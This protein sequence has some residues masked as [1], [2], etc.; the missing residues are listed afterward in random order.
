[1]LKQQLKRFGNVIFFL[2]IMGLTIYA[3][4]H[5]QNLDEI[6]TSLREITLPY[7]FCAV[8]VALF[9]VGAEGVI[10][11]SLLRSMHGN[12]G[13]IK[14]IGYAFVGF[15]Y[16]GITPSAS[17][18]QP[19]QLLY[20]KR[21]GNRLSE[22]SVV[23]MTVALLYKFVLVCMGIGILLFWRQPLRGYLRG[24]YGLFLIG[25]VLNTS[26]VLVLLGAMLAPVLIRHILFAIDYLLVKL[27]ILKPSS[28]RRLRIDHFIGGYQ[29]AVLFLKSHLLKVFGAI[30]F[31]FFQRI[32][33]FGLPFIVYQGFSLEG[34]SFLT[35]LCLQTSIYI[36][37]DMLP[38]PGAQGITE[39]MYRTVFQTVFTGAYLM[40]GLYVTRGISFYLMLGV[41]LLVMLAFQIHEK[42]ALIHVFE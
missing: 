41:S 21:D 7:L 12:S 16:S 35:I 10:I 13:L 38:I 42:R 33:V 2:I 22:S 31:T 28:D 8:M 29:E 30:L 20:M 1:M 18:G 4:L 36:A 15:F 32:C 17:G 25:M 6:A 37:V 26:L 3:V 27:H 9:F 39:L 11:W 19:M 40:P 23:L 34:S 5:G 14:C 24:Y